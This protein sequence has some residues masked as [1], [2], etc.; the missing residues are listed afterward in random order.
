VVSTHLKNISQIGNLPQLTRGENNKDL[1]CHHPVHCN[2]LSE[3]NMA[4]ENTLLVKEIPIGNHE[5]LGAMLVSGRVLL[6]SRCFIH[7]S[8]PPIRARHPQ[9]KMNLR[10]AGS[11]GKAPRGWMGSLLI[12]GDPLEK[13]KHG[14][15]KS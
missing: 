2:A 15:P 5:F 6:F 10:L 3:T 8:L 7:D 11:P 1:S 14:V 9:P 13:K 12:L 4:P